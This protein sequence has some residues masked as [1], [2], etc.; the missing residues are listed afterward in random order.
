MTEPRLWHPWLRINRVR[1]VML[2]AHDLSVTRLGV[3]TAMRAQS[4]GQPRSAWL[5]YDI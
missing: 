5:R 3:K 1:R 4:L 2:L